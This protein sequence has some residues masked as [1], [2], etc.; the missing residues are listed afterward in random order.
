MHEQ[1]RQDMLLV[2]KALEQMDDL[3]NNINDARWKF[4]MLSRKPELG[5]AQQRAAG[6][7]P[8]ELFENVHGLEAQRDTAVEVL[9]HLTNSPS[10][11]VARTSYLRV[12]TAYSRHMQLIEMGSMLDIGVPISDEQRLAVL[13]ND[14]FA[15]DVPLC[16]EEAGVTLGKLA[17]LIQAPEM[18]RATP[19]SSGTL[20]LR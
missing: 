2:G 4:E 9:L 10:I 1:I 7:T 6:V 16:I 11:E 8:D 20:E 18:Q 3:T 12:A 15:K 14:S 19:P 13:G 5:F 17:K